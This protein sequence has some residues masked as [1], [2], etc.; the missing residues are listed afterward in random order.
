MRP[1]GRCATSAPE[2][3]G[4]ERH[5][6]SGQAATGR[7]ARPG[8]GRRQPV[9]QLVHAHGQHGLAVRARRGVLA[10]GRP[11]LRRG[12]R[13]PADRDAV[14]GGAGQHREPP[15]L[16]QRAGALPAPHG[17]PHRRAWSPPRPRSR[18]RSGCW[19]S[20]SRR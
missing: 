6:G 17:R 3:G 9:P 1:R 14:G 4:D 19:W 2:G 15:G 5:G 8:D 16:P 20:P 11:P 18:A 12:R 10:R 7:R 13:R